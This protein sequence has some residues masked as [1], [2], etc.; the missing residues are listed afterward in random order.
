MARGGRDLPRVMSGR[1]V[2]VVWGRFVTSILE[3]FP[4]LTLGV[5]AETHMLSEAH[6]AL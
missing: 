5:M 3:A 4:E 2:T 1:R 6:T